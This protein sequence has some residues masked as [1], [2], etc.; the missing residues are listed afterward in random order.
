MTSASNG[1]IWKPDGS[2]LSPRPCDPGWDPF[3]RLM[4]PALRGRADSV[5]DPWTGHFRFEALLPGDFILDAIG[6]RFFVTFGTYRQAS[7][8]IPI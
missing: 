1:A 2:T 8:P 7:R 5:I 3:E 4:V 6:P